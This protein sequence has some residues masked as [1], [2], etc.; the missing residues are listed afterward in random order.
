MQFHLNPT[1]C[2]LD[3]TSLISRTPTLDK[4]HCNCA[5]H[6]KKCVFGIVIHQ[7]ATEFCTYIPSERFSRRARTTTITNLDLSC[8]LDIMPTNSSFYKI[9]KLKIQILRRGKKRGR[10]YPIIGVP[11]TYPSEI[12]NTRACMFNK[13]WSQGSWRG[14]TCNSSCLSSNS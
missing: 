7:Y 1:W 2:L 6:L 12:V 4:R 11:E 14:N 5:T 13:R 3:R 9:L 10:K 8:F